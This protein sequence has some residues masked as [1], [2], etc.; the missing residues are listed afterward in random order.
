MTREKENLDEEISRPPVVVILGHVD[1]GKSSIL[2]AIKDLKITE[3]ESG[4][5]TQHIGA[6]E[7]EKDGKK[8][9]FIDTPGHEAFSS[10]R[11]RGTKVADIVVL[12]VA[13]DE[14]V[15]TQTKEAINLIR[16]SG[17]PIVVAINKID[18][19]QAQIEKV[20]RELG[21]NEILVES[22]G[23]K[24]PS[25]EL[26]AKTG[27][28]IERLL[29]MIL[30]VAE[31]E[32]LK[33]D[34][35]G[36]GEGTIIEA[37]LDEKKGPI[38]TLILEK[39]T[40]R[41]QQ[42]VGTSSTWGKIKN[43]V[44]FQGF[45]IKSAKPSQPVSILGFEKTPRV[46][47]KFKVY[48]NVD[49]AIGKIEKKEKKISSVLFIEEGKK[50]LNIILKT[51][52]L[53][54]LEAIEDIL[55]NIPQEKVILR[56]LKSEVGNIQEVDIKL[57]ESSKAQIFGFR[58]KVDPSGLN[59]LRQRKVKVKIFEIIYE[60]V[61][62]VRRAMEKILEP[63]ILRKDLG[64]IEISNLFSKRK[65]RQ[66]IGGRV[67][68]GF[69]EKGKKCEILR[70]EEVIGQ[71]KIINLQQNRKDIERAIKGSECGIL[72]ETEIKI[73]QGDVLKIY[74]EERKK[75]EL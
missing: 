56:I 34:I 20:K 3:K 6:Y 67:I 22:L 51:D 1:H 43:L 54:S 11:A 62:G 68:E 7:I 73:E 35:S 63:E 14:G 53:G 19:P 65:N 52:V 72:F 21:E 10:M 24:I 16:K 23:G 42:I 15:K 69:M 61:Q 31:M 18:K 74:E 55:K 2:E 40:L 71:G 48:A 45:P 41:E 29:D 38:A 28:G 70:G 33:T 39:G 25:V 8:I 27:Q 30:L 12:V 13:A 58:I 57:A 59:L 37:Y 9:T 66:T 49:Q 75:R 32:G 46:G 36:S 26:S 60:L 44:D 17:I 64:E 5:I 4:G 47:D 50:V